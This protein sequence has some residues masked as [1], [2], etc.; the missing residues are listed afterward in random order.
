MLPS[1]KTFKPKNAGAKTGR[2][3]RDKRVV[4]DSTSEKD[5]WWAA[6]DGKASNGS[7]NYEMDERCANSCL[8][9][10]ALF[11]AISSRQVCVLGF[12]LF[13]RLGSE[14]RGNAED[15]VL[16]LLST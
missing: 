4:K 8:L 16:V 13:V 3:P 6:P 14:G 9:H 7:P 1:P 12:T 5:V 15:E 10:C 2:S 11:A